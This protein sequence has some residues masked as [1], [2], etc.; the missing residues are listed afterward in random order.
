MNK[1][2]A[3]DHPDCAGGIV[4]SACELRWINA[5]L[6]QQAERIKD[7]ED[8]IT[9]HKETAAINYDAFIEAE[10]KL[11]TANA[12]IEQARPVIERLS[13]EV[14]DDYACHVQEGG[15]PTGYSA[16]EQEILSLAAAIERHQKGESNATA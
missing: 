13:E 2:V 3:A 10:S 9:F 8:A 5:K 12:L 16:S 11:A 1:V 7:Q 14:S 4:W 6:E 15:N